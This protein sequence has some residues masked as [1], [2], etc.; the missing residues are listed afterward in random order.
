MLKSTLIKYLDDYLKI[1]DFT[2]DSKNG[3]QVDSE[4]K[5]IKKIWYAVD[6]TSYIFDKAIKEKVDLVLVHHGMF[7]WFEKV[8]VGPM[9]SKIKKLINNDIGLYACHL[10]L[11]AHAQV[12]NNAVLADLF[13]KFFKI[14]NCKR[15]KFGNYHNHSIGRWIRFKEKISFADLK[16]F[17][18]AIG[19]QE[20]MYDFG[21]KKYIQ[22]VAFISGGWLSEVV[23]AHNENYDLFLT[24]EWPH[25]EH[26]HAKEIWQSIITGGHYETEVFWPQALAQHLA[27]KFKIQTVFLDEKY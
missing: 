23:W 4:K 27:K 10:P 15:Q 17:C 7:R 8:I 9:Y 16:R 6:A 22:S 14:K 24:G 20:V 21:N 26:I 13:V 5:E 1:A 3:L 19:I 12:G 11:D 18:K 2:D 25:H